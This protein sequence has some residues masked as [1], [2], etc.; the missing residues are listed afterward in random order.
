MNPSPPYVQLYQVNTRLLLSESG[1]GLGRPATL[2]D[3]SDTWLQDL[4]EH[5]FNWLYLLGAWDPGQ[6]GRQLALQ[7]NP[8]KNELRQVLPDL[9]EADIVGSCFATVGYCIPDAY[10]GPAALRRLRQRL[11]SFGMRLMMDFIPNHTAMDHPWVSEHP[12]YYVNGTEADLKKQP[13]G[14]FR[15]TTDT[16]PHILAHGK[17]P[18]F[19]AWNDTVQ[20]DY[21]NPL[22]QK[23]MINEMLTAASQCDGLRVD[24]A[25]LALPDVFYGTWGLTAQPFWPVA[26]EQVRQVYPDFIFLGE[27]YWNLEWALQQ[28]GFDFTYDKQFYDHL[29]SQDATRV[30]K[31]LMM[32]H[33]VLSRMAHFLENHDEPRAA[34]RFPLAIH[35]AA[36]ALLYLAPGLR[37]F[38]HGQLQGAWTRVPMQLIRGPVETNDEWIETFYH[39]LTEAL[40]LPAV[41]SGAWQL[42]DIRPDQGTG[43]LARKL[44]GYIWRPLPGQ[45][46]GPVLAL[47]NYSPSLVRSITRLPFEELP[48]KKL[49]LLDHLTGTRLSRSGDDLFKNGLT[50]DMAPWG[51]YIL[52]AQ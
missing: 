50:I 9:T 4:A 49:S 10:G 15:V 13:D 30:K 36:A 33:A 35:R 47:V 27:V 19:P 28:Q 8:L 38:Q 42:L 41:R 12:E 7:N 45:A 11:H 16:G 5:G 24:M 43:S 1:R 52:E 14:Y 3:I 32:P 34:A 18:Y 25:M 21:S 2:D 26:I 40:K 51:V 31:H 6:R 44:I 17:D 29:V 39:K 20:I 22:T 46:A 37:F 48:G 23:A